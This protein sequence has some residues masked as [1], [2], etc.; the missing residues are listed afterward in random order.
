MR[1]EG[2]VGALQTA[3][4]DGVEQQIQLG[5]QGEL[6]VGGAA[7]YTSI[8]QGGR[9]WRA[10]TAV[11]GVAPGTAIGTTAAFALHNPHG[12]A[13]DLAILEISMGYISGTLG[14]GTVFVCANGAAKVNEAAP[15]G[16]AITVINAR[17]G[18]AD[19]SVA[20]PFTTATLATAPTPILPIFCPGASLASTAAIPWQLVSD[21][22]GGLVI[23]P[24]GVMS[25]QAVAA[26]GTSPLVVY[27][28][29]W[30]EIPN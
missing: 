24:G 3:L 6:V 12:S 28:C 29:L 1:L 27:G 21:I 11:S 15:T 22:G 30:Q 19:S 17:I 9:C 4:G 20:K 10:T 7:R 26:A 2:K 16:T 23:G 18:S 5:K 13:V 8:V 25:L 14:A